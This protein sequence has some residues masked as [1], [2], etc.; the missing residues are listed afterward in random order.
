[1]QS[2]VNYKFC[3]FIDVVFNELFP[4]IRHPAP[5]MDKYTSYKNPVLSPYNIQKADEK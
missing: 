2:R 5:I 3:F 1:M 4:S